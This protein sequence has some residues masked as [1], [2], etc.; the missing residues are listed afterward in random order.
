MIEN[1]KY[2]DSVYFMDGKMIRFGVIKGMHENFCE[3]E[4]WFDGDMAHY[5]I[6][7]EDM[8]SK[9]EELLKEVAEVIKDVIEARKRLK[10]LGQ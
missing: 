6:E 8:W 2:G 4:V 10:H 9:K 7:Y 1:P 5:L 3:V